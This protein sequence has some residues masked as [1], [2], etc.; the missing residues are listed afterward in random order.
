MR[1]IN[2]TLISNL[3]IAST[4]K[5]LTFCPWLDRSFLPNSD[6]SVYRRSLWGV[7]FLAL[8]LKFYSIFRFQNWPFWIWSYL[9]YRLSVSVATVCHRPC[10]HSILL[11]AVLPTPIHAYI[12]YHDVT[13]RG[14]RGRDHYHLKWRSTGTKDLRAGLRLLKLSVLCKE[15][16]FNLH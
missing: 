14:H 2:T 3:P 6:S 13:Y 15:N 4:V 8:K 12:R 5:W 1:L 10:T 9:I 16:S 11:A 7:F